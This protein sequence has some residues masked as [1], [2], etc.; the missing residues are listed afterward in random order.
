MNYMKDFS[1]S[2]L[3]HVIKVAENTTSRMMFLV[4][5]IGLVEKSIS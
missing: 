1:G 4:L 5:Y 2:N 3:F